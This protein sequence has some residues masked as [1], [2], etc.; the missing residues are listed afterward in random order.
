MRLANEELHAWRRERRETGEADAVPREG[1]DRGER[2]QQV[3][4]TRRPIR[5]DPIRRA[6]VEEKRRELDA[7]IA[8]HDEQREPPGVGADVGEAGGDPAGDGSPDPERRDGGE[9]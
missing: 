8:L 3:A 2:A 1:E 9:P 7:L 4:G 5:E 6:R